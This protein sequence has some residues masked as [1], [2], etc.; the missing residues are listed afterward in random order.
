MLNLT[1]GTAGLM[2][3][4]DADPA[5]SPDGSLVAFAYTMGVDRGIYVMDARTGFDV[6]EVRNGPIAAGQPAWGPDGRTITYLLD[7]RRGLTVTT[8]DLDGQLR[9]R[10]ERRISGDYSPAL[11]PVVAPEGDRVLFLSI[12]AGVLNVHAVSTTGSPSPRLLQP[13]PLVNVLDVDWR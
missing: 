12:F 7:R 11:R 13:D 8:A 3:T 5:V 9:T 1:N 4:D 6:R 2:P 10:N